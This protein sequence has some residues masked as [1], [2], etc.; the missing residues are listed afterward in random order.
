MK[1]KD[2]L[3]KHSACADGAR[4]ALSIG[5]DMAD[6]WDAMIE[7]GK[8]DW[9]VWTA[10][11]PGVFSDSILRKLACRC[12]RETPLSD[13]RR[14]WDLLKDERS[15]RAVEVAER[16]AD[17]KA[18]ARELDAARAAARVAS[19]AAYAAARAAVRAADAAT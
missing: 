1:T 18:T 2:F 4:W 9:L 13:G 16:Y 6:V 19:C 5:E 14:V 3:K 15:R 12:V 7:Q 17:G 11:R 8:Y 10:T